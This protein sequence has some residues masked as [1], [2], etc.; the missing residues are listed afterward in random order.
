MVRYADSGASSR[1]PVVLTAH[2]DP[3][4]S[5]WRSWV[6]WFL[7]ISHYVL[8]AYLWP[9]FLVVTVITGFSILFIGRYPR[10][11]FDF[12]SG[13]LR[14]SWPVSSCAADGGLGTGQYPPLRLHQGQSEPT[15][16][17]RPPTVDPAIPLALDPA[18]TRSAS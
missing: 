18:G 8:L 2:L 1:H 9:A 12:T 11:L 13:V 16:P 10:P 17:P 4:L 6:Q 15:L 3:A 5:R 14:W 7:A